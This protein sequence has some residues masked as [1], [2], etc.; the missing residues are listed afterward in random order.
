MNDELIRKF[1]SFQTFM[2][3]PKYIETPI[4]VKDKRIQHGSSLEYVHDLESVHP[5]GHSYVNV[6]VK[7]GD[8]RRFS[9]K[10]M[11]DEIHSKILLRYDS[12]GNA[13]RNNYDDIPLK[14]QQVT[15]PHLHYFDDN[16]RFLAKKTSEILADENRACEIEYGFQ[17]FCNEGN[18]Y[19]KLTTNPPKIQI[20]EQAILPF[21]KEDFDP[22]EGVDF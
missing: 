15:T 4:V 21:E 18:I 12:S 9:A 2:H 5:F 13:H 1:V 11:S 6:E 3:T 20:G 10:L 16:G 7:N 19:G 17:I 14:E 22:C 8:S